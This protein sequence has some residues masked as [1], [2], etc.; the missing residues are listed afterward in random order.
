M[1][2]RE[3]ITKEFCKM[4]E[5]DSPSYGERQMADYVVPILKELGFKVL[6]DNAGTKYQGNCGNIYGYLPGELQGE[7]ILLS[8]HLDT[9]EPG[10]G[11]RAIVH[12]D[13][14][15]T[16]DGTTILGAD[17]LSGI[18]SILEAIRAIKEDKIPHRNV[19]IL[20]SIAEEVYLKGTEIFDFSKIHSKT[21]Y[22]LDL[23]GPIG[24]A[25][26][27]APTLMS[28]TAVIEGKAAHAGF[29]PEQGINAISIGAQAITQIKQGRIDDETTVNIGLLEGGTARNI[30]SDKCVI[31][32]EVRSLN[33]LKA[34]NK[35]KEIEEIF[36]ETALKHN[37]AAH[38]EMEA[39]SISYHVE[40]NHPVVQ[41]FRKACKKAAV[42][43]HLI[44]TFGGSD[45]NNFM[46]HGI[47]GIVM[48]C[49][50][51]RVH[52]CDEFSSIY[53]LEKCSEVVYYILTMK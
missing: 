43:S 37:G 9:V 32:G 12:E 13:G 22:V 24:F 29:A 26:L 50:M 17:D 45:N 47:T 41:R 19:E 28:F 38:F 52:S 6:E 11:K 3:R 25:A 44:D 36:Q 1:I 33:H 16:S 30:V 31:K 8:A 48:A 39:G 18:V 5:I 20:F 4:V 49:G 2:N 7:S 21:A 14:R 46:K 10:R 35:T 27:T 42:H 15:I 53:D 23:S 34:V 40:E 51:N